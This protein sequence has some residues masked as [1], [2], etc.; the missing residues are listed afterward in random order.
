MESKFWNITPKQ[1]YANRFTVIDV[2]VK[3]MSKNLH[4]M[5]IKFTTADSLDVQTHDF[6]STPSPI[7]GLLVHI[8]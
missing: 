8:P 1:F 3:H 6:R 5:S 2:M 4:E 7:P